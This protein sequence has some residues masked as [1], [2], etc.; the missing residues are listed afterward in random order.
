MNLF[1]KLFSTGNINMP[2][3]W[4]KVKHDNRRK[5]KEDKW[6]KV[7]HDERR[8]VKFQNDI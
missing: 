2:D 1:G 4:R 8:K 5:V 6:R 7:K 3:R